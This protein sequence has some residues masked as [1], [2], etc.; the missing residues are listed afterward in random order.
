MSERNTSRFSRHLV[1]FAKK[2]PTASSQEA[3]FWTPAPFQQHAF[4]LLGISPAADL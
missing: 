3:D 2:S 1:N 4:D